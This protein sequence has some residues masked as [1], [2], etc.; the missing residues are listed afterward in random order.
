MA[1][2]CPHRG[3]SL[4][5]GRNEEDGLRCVYHGWKYDATG[6]CVDQM[7]EPDD[8]DFSSKMKNAAYP[9]TEVGGLIW[10][11][12]GPSEK[13]PALPLFAW[14]QVADD[15]RHVNKT[16]EE[17]NWLQAMEGGLDTSHA[18]IMHRRLVDD[19]DLPGV[20]PSS[21]PGI[22]YSSLGVWR[23]TCPRRRLRSAHV[24][25]KRT[26]AH[27][28]RGA[29]MRFVGVRSLCSD[30]MVFRASGSFIA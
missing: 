17:C 8:T 26:V 15:Q 10:A 2:Y 19:T 22:S 23:T 6:Q 14:T 27:P 13:L 24:P 3:A 9:V 16:F 29:Q 11:Y 30:I 20:S 7:N 1:E 4:F 12:L 21:C 28:G 18:P 5:F 25:T